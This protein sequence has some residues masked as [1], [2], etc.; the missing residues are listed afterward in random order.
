MD[1]HT[2]FSY[3]LAVVGVMMIVLYFTITTSAKDKIKSD[4]DSDY[5]RRFDQAMAGI[6]SMGFVFLTSASIMIV[7]EKQYKI[8]LAD[9]M[10]GDETM[11]IVFASV[12]SVVT[13]ILASI[14]ISCLDDGNSNAKGQLSVVIAVPVIVVMAA[15]YT[16]MKS[17]DDASPEIDF[18]FDFEF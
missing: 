8:Q 1:I 6:L 17:G 14:A 5:Q 18:G 7:V 3:M 12:V 9:K 15:I 16:M 4:D 13:I 2:N 10:G 11:Y